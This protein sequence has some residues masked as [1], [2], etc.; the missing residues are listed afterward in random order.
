LKN[1]KFKFLVPSHHLPTR[2]NLH[3]STT[4]VDVLLVLDGELDDGGLAA[5]GEL[6][7]ELG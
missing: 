3:I 4:A 2:T 6:L 7:G 5:V 1:S